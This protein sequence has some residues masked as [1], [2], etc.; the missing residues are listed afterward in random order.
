[1][2]F[3]RPVTEKWHCASEGVFF[4]CEE[5]ISRSGNK[6]TRPRRLRNLRLWPRFFC[7]VSQDLLAPTPASQS[8]RSR[9]IAERLTWFSSGQRIVCWSALLCSG[10]VALRAH[11]FDFI[12][13]IFFAD[14]LVRIAECPGLVDQCQSPKNN[15]PDWPEISTSR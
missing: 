8:W 5:N 7:E 12:F 6:D 3:W 4:G 11:A 9:G 2:P 1:M 15:R 13:D 10:T 14:G